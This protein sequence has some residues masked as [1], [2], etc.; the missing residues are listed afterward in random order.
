MAIIRIN[1]DKEVARVIHLPRFEDT[2]LYTRVPDCREGYYDKAEELSSKSDEWIKKSQLTY[3]SPNNIRRVFITSE[4][5]F[6]HFYQPIVYKGKGGNP[7]LMREKKYAQFNPYEASASITQGRRDYVITKSGLGALSH[8]WVASNIEE[9]Y[10]DWTVLL[11]E[12][13]LNMGLGNLLIELTAKPVP[14]IEKSEIP[15]LIFKHFCCETKYDE[16]VRSRFPRLRVVGYIQQLERVYR[17]V[18]YKP[19]EE[20]VEDM[21][22]LWCANEIVKVA[23]ADPACRIL[24][25]NIPGV[26]KYNLEYRTR[27]GIYLYDLEVLQ[28]YFEKRNKRIIEY[29]QRRAKE[30]EEQI[31]TVKSEIEKQLD[32]MY[33]RDGAEVVTKAIKIMFTSKEL[34]EQTLKEMSTE[35]KRKYKQFFEI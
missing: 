35:G 4:G 32:E 7:S 10:F 8:P 3:G 13:V 18:D 5:V 29:K 15:Y 27:E 9:V 19:G 16:D 26:S 31:V 21:G 25:Y 2:P 17:M 11:S 12:D 22:K 23:G 6:V 24:L 28:P 14:G 33:E 20:T 1:L 34:R 30:Q